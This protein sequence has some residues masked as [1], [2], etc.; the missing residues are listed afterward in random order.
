LK[1][2]LAFSKRARAPYPLTGAPSAR[3]SAGGPES[4]D[5][6]AAM[7]APH[8]ALTRRNQRR[9]RPPGE[10]DERDGSDEGDEGDEG[11]EGDEE[12]D[13]DKLSG[14]MN[15]NYAL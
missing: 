13:V 4:L 11:E 2:R 3:G 12:D 10:R 1:N 15:G 6:H 14:C 5:V 9:R 7:A 8:A